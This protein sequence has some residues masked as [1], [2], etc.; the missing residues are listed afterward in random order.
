MGTF[1]AIANSILTTLSRGVRVF[2]GLLDEYGG[3]AAA[4]SV[5]RLSSDYATPT[6]SEFSFGNALD[7]DGTN[8]YVSFT[9]IALTNTYS[10]SMWFR[11]DSNFNRVLLTK[12]TAPDWILR[13]FSTTIIRIYDGGIKDWTVPTLSPNT[14]YHLGISVSSGTGRLYLNAV[15]SSTGALAV[16][17]GS[18]N[19]IG[20]N[21]IGGGSLYFGGRLDETAI[22]QGVAATAQNFVDL[23]NGGN[24]ALASSVIASP[25]AY[26]RMNGVADDSTAIDE[27]G[28]YNG[29]LNNFNTAT[30]WVDGK[31]NKGALLEIR[32]SSD[33]L[34]KNFYYDSNNELSLNSKD[35]NGTTLSSWIGSDDG[36]VSTWYDQSGNAVNVQQTTPSLQAPIISAGSLLVDNGKPMVDFTG[37]DYYLTLS[38]TITVSWAFAVQNATAIDNV[39]N[40]IFGGSGEGCFV[41]G[42]TASVTGW[43]ITGGT[44]QRESDNE[45]LGQIIRTWSSDKL[46]ANG[47]EEG[48]SQVQS[49]GDFDLIMLGNRSDALSFSFTGYLQEAILYNSNQESNVVGIYENQNDYYSIYSP[50][51]GIGTW[52]IGTT[53]IIQ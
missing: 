42:T 43:G 16:S 27:Q 34:V 11:T 5:R 3:A 37:G 10:I 21:W 8:D 17:D 41:G 24:G 39:V 4:Y 26:W 9:S 51:S 35:W 45:N 30:C 33:N 15:E 29:T 48:Y 47:V 22:W 28:T 53:F 25:T 18:V 14:W 23:Y 36:F 38:S 19:W 32:R 50:P 40:Y 1:I 6:N 12:S 31:A 49:A 44:G 52:A 7:F 20:R 13:L 46:F 2:S